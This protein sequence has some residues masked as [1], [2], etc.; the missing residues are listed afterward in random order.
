MTTFWHG[1][2]LPNTTTETPDFGLIRRGRFTAA[3]CFDFTPHDA[4]RRVR[5]E[6]GIDRWL[7]RLWWPGRPA[8]PCP[9]TAAMIPKLEGLVRGPLAGCE[10]VVEIHN[11][12]NHCAGIEGWGHEFEHIANFQCWYM[13]VY[14][15]LRREFPHEFATCYPGLANG[16]AHND[17][18]WYLRSGRALEVSDYV[19]VHTYWQ[20][21]H[22]LDWTWG[23]RYAQHFRRFT[24]ERMMI[25]E[26]GDS[27]FAG[28]GFDA[29]EEARARRVYEWLVRVRQNRVAGA[30]WFIL[31]GTEDWRGF[32]LTERIAEAMAAA[33]GKEIA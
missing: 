5:G 23:L 27:S 31:G 10:V 28:H 2:H 15:L 6:C 25:T 18:E 17:F 1:I 20:G 24:P 22:H 33:V 3:K 9:Y 11:E 16:D 30:F 4:I 13:A 32:R 29:S 14:W 19:G 8:E 26:Y 7:V 21:E 12:P